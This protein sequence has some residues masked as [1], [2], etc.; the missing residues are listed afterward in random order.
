MENN[1][2][3]LVLK[4]KLIL[5][6]GGGHFGK[7]AI[8]SSKSS[9]AKVILIDPNE[10]CLAS[11]FADEKVYN[12]DFEKLSKINSGKAI[13]FIVDG[14]E[15]LIKLIKEGKIPDFIAPAV[16]GHLAA[17]VLKTFLEDSGLKVE[18]FFEVGKI[19]EDI[20]KS[21]IINANKENGI[22]VLSYMPKDKSCNLPCDQPKEYCK[23]T[24]RPKFG[25]IYKLME[26]AIWNKVDTYC[27]LRSYKLE[28]AVGCFEGEIFYSFLNELKTKSPP[29]NLAIV[30]SCGC[31]GVVNFF[32][33][34]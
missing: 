22:I 23:T 33:V 1:K 30:T 17:K 9:L 6:V 31:H 28:T 12:Y 18:T 3:D 19:I 14:I 4:D 25:P 26:F 27:I 11:S 15:F 24:K 13:F 8:I 29:Y 5:I 2:R 10:N 32:S 20:P 34:K 7:E 16:P 21:L